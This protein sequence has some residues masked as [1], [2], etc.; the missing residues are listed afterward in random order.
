MNLLIWVSDFLIAKKM[1]MN[2][3]LLAV[4]LLARKSDY[5]KYEQQHP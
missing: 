1:G 4:R 3:V 2:T 5:E